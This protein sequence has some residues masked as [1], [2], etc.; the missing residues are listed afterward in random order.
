MDTM[1][2]RVKDVVAFFHV[3]EKTIYRWVSQEKLPFHRIN[4]QYRF[5]RSELLEWATS[6]RIP[7]P[8]QLMKEPEDAVIPS[9]AEALETGGIYY[10]VEGRDKPA[11]LNSVVKILSLPQEVDREFLYQVLLARE[12]LGSTGIGGGIAIPHVRNPITLHVA[13]PLIA[14]CF[15][16][17]P[18]NFEAIDG[19]AVHTLFTIVSPTTKAHLNLLSKL[20]F[21][22][23]ASEFADAVSRI[24]SREH[25]LQAARKLDEHLLKMANS[26]EK[27]PS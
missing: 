15:L 7:I 3:S 1:K 21:G 27:K 4:N 6:N 25:I 12:S 22:L 19:E 5:N 18:I 23:R 24:D 2:L 11:V 13:R 17:D 20:S 16:E 9:L 8:P 26:K 10:R 14:L